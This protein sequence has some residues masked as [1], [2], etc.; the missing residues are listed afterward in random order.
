M[1]FFSHLG[2]PKG[3]GSPL[4]VTLELC[5]VAVAWEPVQWSEIKGHTFTVQRPCIGGAH[6]FNI[7]HGSSNVHWYRVH[8]SGVGHCSWVLSG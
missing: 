2:P 6:T 8:S 4:G 3:D 7:K 1:M 5:N